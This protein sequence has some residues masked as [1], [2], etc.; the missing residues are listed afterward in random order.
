MIL[1]GDPDQIRPI[2][3]EKGAGTPALDISRAFPQHVIYLDE[4]MRQRDDARQIYSVVTSVRKKQPDAIEW[5]RDIA[6]PKQAVVILI[7][8]GGPSGMLAEI[9]KLIHR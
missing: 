8:V 3:D 6:D 2:P 1:I 5:G 7:P 9:T 4:N